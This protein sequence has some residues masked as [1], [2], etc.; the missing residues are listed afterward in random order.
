MTDLR[1]PTP[2]GLNAMLGRAAVARFKAGLHRPLTCPGELGCDEIRKVWKGM[3]GRRPALIA[4]C[5]GIIRLSKST[6]PQDLG[7]PR[8]TYLLEE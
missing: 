5:A 4:R 3:I 6:F 8:R 1:A 7:Q 2:T